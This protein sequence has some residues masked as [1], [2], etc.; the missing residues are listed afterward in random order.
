M[1]Q[2]QQGYAIVLI[3][4]LLILKIKKIQLSISRLSFY[5]KE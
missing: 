1:A 5:I 2:T 3:L 4:Y